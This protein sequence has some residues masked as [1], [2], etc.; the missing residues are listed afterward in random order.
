MCAQSGTC[1]YGNFVQRSCGWQRMDVWI[2]LWLTETSQQ[3][4]ITTDDHHHL[5]VNNVVIAYNDF[6]LC[7][8]SQ[9]P[10]KNPPLCCTFV[11]GCALGGAL[12]LVGHPKN[13]VTVSKQK[14]TFT[15][16]LLFSQVR[17]WTSV[18][19]PLL[20]WQ[21]YCTRQAGVRGLP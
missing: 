5:V 15:D 19:F 1:T 18:K 12:Q 2:C 16:S 20:S 11:Q 3:Q 21:H 4:P 10:P 13:R 14:P 7:H 6:E 8:Q 17:A 9:A